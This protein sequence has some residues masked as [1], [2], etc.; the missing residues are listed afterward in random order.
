[1][2]LISEELTTKQ[3]LRY[4]H[5]TEMLDMIQSD[6]FLKIAIRLENVESVNYRHYDKI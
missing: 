4:G 5:Y 6:T 1:M 3:S 2:G